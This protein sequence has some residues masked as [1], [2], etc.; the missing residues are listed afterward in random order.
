MRLEDVLHRRARPGAF[1]PND[2]I[3][4]DQPLQRDAPFVRE[5]VI[6]RGDDDQRVLRKR[7]GDRRKLARWPSHDHEIDFVRRE[8][9]DDLFAI[10]DRKADRYVR[11]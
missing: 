10:A 11:I 6:G 8:Q 5:W 1:L 9:L 7:R 2:K 3:L 4:V